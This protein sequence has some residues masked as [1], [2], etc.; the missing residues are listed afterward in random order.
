[1]FRR[2]QEYFRF[3]D[4]YRFDSIYN[5]FH[6]RDSAHSSFKNNLIFTEECFKDDHLDGWPFSF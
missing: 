6:N 3:F 2:F 5:E 1:M 4:G